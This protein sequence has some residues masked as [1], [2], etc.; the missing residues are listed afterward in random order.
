MYLVESISSCCPLSGSSTFDG[1]SSPCLISFL[2][3][4]DLSANEHPEKDAEVVAREL[5]LH[6]KTLAEKPRLVCGSKLDSAIDGNGKINVGA[7]SLVPQ[8][9]IGSSLADGTAA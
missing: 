2:H 7:V 4:V 8:S 6:S 1:Y 5:E 3:L 9:P